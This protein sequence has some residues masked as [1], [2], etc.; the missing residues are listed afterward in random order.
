MT[1]KFVE[2][3][4]SETIVAFTSKLG[5]VNFGQCVLD[6]VYVLQH[7]DLSFVY[8]FMILDYGFGTMTATTCNK[9]FVRVLSLIP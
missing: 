2:D 8:G 4:H 1:S 9:V 3:V 5:P 7:S 6:N